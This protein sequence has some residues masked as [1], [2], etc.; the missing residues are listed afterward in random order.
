MLEQKALEYI[1][2]HEKEYYELL[3]TLAQIPAP[4]NH[5]EKRAEFLKTLLEGWGLQPEIDKALN[6]VVPYGVTE[7]KPLVVFMAHT[8]VVFPD[9][10][11]L[12]L[13]IDGDKLCCPGIGD[14]TAN[15][16]A[17]LL[18]L[19][20]MAENGI[21]SER[22]GYLFVMNA[23]EEGLG[24]LKGSKQIVSDY[25]RRIQ[26][27]YSFDGY[28]GGI[29]DCAVGSKRMKVTVTT[30][31]GHS[32][33]AFGNKNAIQKAACMIQ[34]IYRIQ[35]PTEGKTTYN[36]GTIS[37][38]TSVNSIAQKCVFLCEYRSDRLDGM[39]YMDDQYQEIFS[40]H[41]QDGVGIFVETVGN[42]PCEN[43]SPEGLRKREE[44]LQLSEGI[45]EQYTGE[46]PK[47]GSGSTDCNSALAA[48]IPAVC[49]G[50]VFGNGPHT[51]EEYVLK[52]SLTMGY[53]A[54]LELVLKY[55]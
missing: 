13:R 5:E 43:L 3:L 48:G 50:T 33:A 10:E 21:T 19:H 36:V 49:F 53:K 27:F 40:R 51:R 47:R 14:D 11:T 29:T 35:V 37:G 2:S 25:G 32:Y 20:Y 30:E 22:Y 41:R 16:V 8:D 54:A 42:R 26:A 44:M 4:S 17:M 31:G 6:V 23:G 45:V 9:T 55:L 15:V 24:N 46:K 12:P 34:D 7:D 18:A 52:S 1:E 38:G 28:L 39:Q